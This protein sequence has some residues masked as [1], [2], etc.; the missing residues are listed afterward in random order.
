MRIESEVANVV[1]GSP[2][3]FVLK[4]VITLRT[5]EAISI[6]SVAW[7]PHITCQWIEERADVEHGQPL[8]LLLVV[9]P[10]QPAG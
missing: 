4:T 10:S 6:I 3:T 8:R 1:L 9:F 5:M 7:M 2:K